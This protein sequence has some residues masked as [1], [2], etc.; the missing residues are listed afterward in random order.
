MLER[1]ER[2]ISKPSE[3]KTYADAGAKPLGRLTCY[4]MDSIKRDW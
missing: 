1:S 3:V 2:L 4:F